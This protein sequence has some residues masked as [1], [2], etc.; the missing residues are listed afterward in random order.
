[1]GQKLYDIGFD[2]S[3]D[4]ILEASKKRAQRIMNPVTRLE[5]RGNQ[6]Q[7]GQQSVI[8]MDDV[9]EQVRAI[10]EDHTKKFGY[11]S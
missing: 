2:T 6:C 5:S 9:P 7:W 10:E 11:G 8:Y 4:D 1:M 3:F